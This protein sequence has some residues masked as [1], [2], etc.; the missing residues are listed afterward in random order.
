MWCPLVTLVTS[1]LVLNERITWVAPA[2]SALILCEVYVAERGFRI[3]FR[4]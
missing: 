1:W 3:V 4:K 2:G